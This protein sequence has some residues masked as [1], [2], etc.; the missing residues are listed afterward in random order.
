MDDAFVVRGSETIGVSFSDAQGEVIGNEIRDNDYGIKIAGKSDVRIENNVIA[1]SLY[2]AVVFQSGSKG[3][4][5]GNRLV[6]NGGGIVVH[7]GAQ[8]E[9]SGNIIPSR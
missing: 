3:A 1:N 7:D 6:K 4:V 2:E 5:V 9:L 8:A